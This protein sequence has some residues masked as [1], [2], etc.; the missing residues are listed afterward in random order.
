MPDF[1]VSIAQFIQAT[2]VP[3]Q[4]RE[5]DVRGL[6]TNWYFLL[7]FLAVMGHIIYRK[8]MNTFL[9]LSLGFGVWMFSGSPYM[10]NLIIDGEM[11]LGKVLPMVG[12][13]ILAISV[14]VYVLFIRSD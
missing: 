7:L 3:E 8:A 5:V 4:F 2:Q 6:F 13:G 12:V 11:Q 10:E 9:L 14:L 1:L